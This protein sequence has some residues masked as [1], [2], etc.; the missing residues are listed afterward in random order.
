MLFSQIL[1]EFGPE[2]EVNIFFHHFN[3]KVLKSLI[4]DNQGEYSHY[5]LIPFEHPEIEESLSLLPKKNTYLIDI[6]P[7]EYS[8]EYCGVHQDFENDIYNILNQIKPKTLNYESLLLINHK[9]DKHDIPA[10]I[11][12]GFS[13]FCKENK[14][15]HNV[16][17]APQNYEPQKG[18]GY[19]VVDDN[20][21][22]DLIIQCNK[23]NFKPGKDIGILSYNESPLKQ[24]I[25]TGISVI[26][27]DF[28]QMG[29]IVAKM[30]KEGRHECIK[31]PFLFVDRGSF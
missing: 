12:K 9:R 20:D 31:N 16:I 14:I 11:S 10:L 7:K 23:T 8:R 5:I 28:I 26:S 21:L 15:Q 30:L 2:S 4:K 18:T 6:L 27:T 24:V 17:D 22:V 1:K 13:R 29:A 25:T 19:I 3:Q